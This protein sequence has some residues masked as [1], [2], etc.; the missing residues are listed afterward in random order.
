[1]LVSTGQKQMHGTNSP[2]RIDFGP[3]YRGSVTGVIEAIIGVVVSVVGING[4]LASTL[5]GAV[6]SA[7]GI[8]GTLASVVGIAEAIIGA[9]ASIAPYPHRAGD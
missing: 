4:T 7:G 9:V 2:I 3:Q 5:I 1:M 6:A 8:N